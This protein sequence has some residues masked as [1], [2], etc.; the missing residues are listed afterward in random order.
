MKRRRIIINKQLN[1][2]R[3]YFDNKVNN[4]FE[5]MSKFD[6]TWLLIPFIFYGIGYFIHN[7]YLADYSSIDFEIIQTKYIYI[8]VLFLFYALGFLS[9]LLINLNP[10]AVIKLPLS[11]FIFPWL[12]RF[13]ILILIV[14]FLI[15]PVDVT[16]LTLYKDAKG[17][18]FLIAILV[19]SHIAITLYISWF[20]AG[21]SASSPLLIL[22]KIIRIY[23]SISTI[24]VGYISLLSLRKTYF[25]LL[26]FT[27]AF[28]ALFVFTLILARSIYELK[29]FEKSIL[30][31]KMSTG[32]VFI[33]FMFFLM[34]LYSKNIYKFIP[35]SFG[36]AKPVYAIIYT[37][38][39]TIKCRIINEN[40]EWL[41]IDKGGVPS[42]QRIRVNGIRDIFVSEKPLYET[43]KPKKINVNSNR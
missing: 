17:N 9:L 31:S 30:L 27:I 20:V 25:S 18:I 39:D 33:L 22:Q 12:L 24:P 16:P 11:L 1:N 5:S 10:T 37:E 26:D 36:G 34:I 42:Y 3:K 43:A 15:G 28:L 32:F 8:G 40:S 13:F 23:F 19:Y 38:I 29:I 41:L 14:F 35:P 6:K 2:K 21:L 4:V 7:S